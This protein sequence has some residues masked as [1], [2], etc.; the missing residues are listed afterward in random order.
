MSQTAYVRISPRTVL[1]LRLLWR[2]AFCL[3]ALVFGNAVLL[4]VPQAR[5]A[6]QLSL[7]GA[8]LADART[9][10]Y[11]LAVHYWALSAWFVARLLLSRRFENDSLGARSSHPYVNWVAVTLPRILALLATLP[12][13]VL[14][15]QTNRTVGALTLCA[16][17]LF[18]LLLVLRTKIGSI[19]TQTRQ[20]AGRAP[21]PP[22]SALTEQH[23]Y[24]AFDM[25]GPVSRQT[26][27]GLF[28]FAFALLAG[29]WQ[30]AAG[31]ILGV[32][33]LLAV[34]ALHAY[35]RRRD[36]PKRGETR[37]Q[38]WVVVANLILAGATLTLVGNVQDEIALARFLAS[39]ALL[40]FALGGVTLFGALA[41]GYLPM[42]R[43]FLG[44]APWL[45]PL[46][47]LLGSLVETHWVA[48]RDCPDCLSTVD[49]R[50]ARPTL[51]KHFSA[52][53]QKVPAGEP[54]FVVASV[55]G[56]SRAAYWSGTVLA[57]MEDEAQAHG[58]RFAA[59]LFAI[60]G[61]SGGSLGA[62][63]FVADL[64]QF[65]AQPSCAESVERAH[66]VLAS[67]SRPA[68]PCRL[69]RL[70]AFLGEDFLSPVIGRMLFPDLFVRFTA[71]V[72]P[73]HWTALADRSLGL[74]DAWAQDW[75]AH[76]GSP[77]RPVSWRRPITSL[78]AG[79]E[80]GRLP[81]LLLNTVRL[82]DGQ[83]Y[84]QSNL[85]F[86]LPS[87]QDLLDPRLDTRRLTLAQ[88]V[89][90][91]ARFPYVSPAAVLKA[92]D[93]TR[94]GRLG[95]GG[96]HEPSGAATLADMLQVLQTAQL[97]RTPTDRTGLWACRTAWQGVGPMSRCDVAA[98]PVVAV[99]LDSAAT[100]YPYDYMRSNEGA[101]LDL[102]PDIAAGGMPLPEILAP[103]FGGLSTRND[104]GV[105]SQ[106]RLARL[107]GGG[108]DALVELRM[109]WWRTALDS[110]ELT[111]TCTGYDEQPSMTWALNACSRARMLAASA[112]GFGE[113]RSAT[114]A[115][116]ALAGNLARMRRLIG[117]GTT[118]MPLKGGQ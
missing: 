44:V 36:W 81:S 97:L 35:D 40:L 4:A 112:R 17:T 110:P 56:A 39:P 58:R 30:V 96:Y 61:V 113:G 52:W 64:A 13:G 45:L 34:L 59:N 63:A 47:V 24:A 86:A 16:S 14:T 87:V 73:S 85:K 88:A 18:L 77:G 11:V 100:A 99:I 80:D 118:P 65:P 69:E 5:E 26:I 20:R 108:A 98:S 10:F 94:L 62:A 115:E 49:W 84:V 41:L 19:V 104:L 21:G 33:W 76:V 6:L 8:T 71:P 29:L 9:W 109:P 42:S 37:E 82:E 117:I 1:L 102:E 67:A 32:G 12:V 72:L 7:A 83:R 15:W 75:Q 53:I 38:L 23:A 107:V 106:R 93:G 91:S 51:E 3:L 116:Q 103:V 92:T 25:L 22:A 31:R 68:G 89:H 90:N 114:Q 54:V 70:A 95:D 78:Y 27:L 74:E 57:R 101:L 111:A 55:G 66:A 105:E 50:G 48:Q 2:C 46:L 43:G 79:D 60:S 28:G